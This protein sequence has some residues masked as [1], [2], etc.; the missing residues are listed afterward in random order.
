M[1][2]LNRLEINSFEYKDKIAYKVLNDE[3]TYGELWKRALYYSLLL[4]KC[5]SGPVV[6][7]GNKSVN[8]LITIIACLIARR[9]YVPIDFCTPVSRIK[10]IINDC[11]CSL[12]ISDEKLLIDNVMVKS[13]EELEDFKDNEII[14][15]END[16]AYIIFTSGSTGVAKGVPISYNNLDNFVNWI[17]NIE[18]IKHSVDWNVLNQA[19]FSFDLS[20]ADLYYSLNNGNTLVSLTKKEQD[21]YIGIFNLLKNNCINFVVV[22]PTFMRMCLLDSSFNFNN[23]PDLKCM[24]F[25]GEVL[26]KSL[27]KKIFN[28]FPDI[29]VIN[30]YGPTEATSAVSYIEIIPSMLVQED[31]LPVGDM[32]MLATHIELDNGEII[33]KGK[34]VFSGYL[35]TVGGFYKED[36]INCFKTG[37]LGLIKNNKLYCLGRKDNQIKFMGYRIELEDI[38]KNIKSIDGV[39]DCAVVALFDCS[40][41]VKKVKA[42]LVLENIDIEELKN[43]L[44]ELIPDYMIPKSFVIL[45]KMPIN[46]NGKIDRKALLKL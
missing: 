35:K 1:K 37:D 7:Y 38:E 3:I 9:S 8:I 28:A 26:D 18:I 20:V 21:S 46:S 36:E 23:F 34:S 13:L 39:I 42:Y 25:C 15:N 12:I 40:N 31:I 19:S 29:K 44:K 41:K 30:A 4:K 27:V 16:I 6:I 2:F 22:T 10:Q 45:E 43:K 5:G 17:S 33:L 11:N 32:S 24:Y 14:E